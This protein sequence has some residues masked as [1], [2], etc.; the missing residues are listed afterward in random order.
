MFV[1]AIFNV[2]LDVQVALGLLVQ[3]GIGFIAIFIEWYGH[4]LNKSWYKHVQC[5]VQT[6]LVTGLRLHDMK[7]S[8][9]IPQNMYMV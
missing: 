9:G 3:A 6:F 4:A 7:A 5:I 2:V 1:H 8:S